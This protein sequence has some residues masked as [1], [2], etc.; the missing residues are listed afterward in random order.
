MRARKKRGQGGRGRRSC[1]VVGQL[2]AHTHTPSHTHT[3]AEAGAEG[4]ECTSLLKHVDCEKI[5]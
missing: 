2:N 3:P 1:E 5:R 4:A